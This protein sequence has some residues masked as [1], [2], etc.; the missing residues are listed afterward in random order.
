[1]TKLEDVRSFV[2]R[3]A[4]RT[5]TAKVLIVTEGEKT[6]VLYFKAC[7][8]ELQLGRNVTVTHNPDGP[9]PD[10]VL[11]YA[12]ELADREQRRGS[13]YDA[14][15]CVMDR[16]RHSTFEKTLNAVARLKKKNFSAIC[17]YPSFE[18]WYLLHYEY[19]RASF[20]VEGNRSAGDCVERALK[21]HWPTY[22]KNDPTVW[23]TLRDRLPEA[24]K[25]AKRA[26]A[27]AVATNE[28]NPSTE[29]DLLVEE[30]QKL[31]G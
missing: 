18:Y 15:Y 8:H 24:M 3:R 31:A 9:T 7:V 21:H 28:L 11:A 16:D 13:P 12:R 5:P 19:T 10:K 6:E 30:L 25:R 20:E 14:V 2:R 27:D 29:A 23:K 22:K 1:M 17:S 26:R 4:C